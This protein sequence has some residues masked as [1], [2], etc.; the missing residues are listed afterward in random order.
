[1]DSECIATS[2]YLHRYMPAELYSECITM[3][4]SFIIF[5]KQTTAMAVVVHLHLIDSYAALL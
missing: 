2:I 5:P 1:M 4:P 3:D